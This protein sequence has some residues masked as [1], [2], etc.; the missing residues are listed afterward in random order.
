LLLFILFSLP[1][2]Y[3]DERKLFLVALSM[4]IAA[5]LVLTS[6]GFDWN[7][8]TSAQSYMLLLYICLGMP[9]FAFPFSNSILSK[10]TDARNASFY[11]GMSYA[12][13]Q[14]GILIS[15]VAVSFVDTKESLIIYCVV[16]MFLWLLGLI[17][18]AVHYKQFVASEE[19]HQ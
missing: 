18:F 4:Q 13:L 6:I 14:S 7:H 19:K 10:I 9:Y 11:Q 2:D 3:F 15:R 17:W 16:L 8:I 12:A 1:S 5:I